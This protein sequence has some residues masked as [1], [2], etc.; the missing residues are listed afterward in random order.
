MSRHAAAA[1]RRTA[2]TVTVAV[3][4]VLAVAAVALG[5]S[6][7]VPDPPQ[8]SGA[9]RTATA[10]DTGARPSPTTPSATPPV[11][12]AARPT[13]GPSATMPSPAATP[14]PLASMRRSVPVHIRVPA[15]GVDADMVSLGIDRA[16][17]MQ[18]PDGPDPVGWY[19]Q[20]PTPGQTGP[21]V[22]AAH[23]TWNGARGAFFDLATLRHGGRIVVDRADGSRATFTV[24]S[25]R[26]YAKSRF[27]TLDVYGNTRGPALRLITCAGRFDRDVRRYSDNVVVYADLTSSR[28]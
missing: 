13:S 3:L 9:Q 27:P 7:Q 4:V 17:R 22:L 26:Q 6:R 11:T 25:T 21:S 16:G 23:V 10:A 24:R 1:G 19:D 15:I 5:L 12:P 20:S 18:V 2:L 14:S 8:V 28:P